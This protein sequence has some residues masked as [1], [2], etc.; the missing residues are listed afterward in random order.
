MCPSRDHLRQS[1]CVEDNYVLAISAFSELAY[2]VNLA[3]PSQSDRPSMRHEPF[4]SGRRVEHVKLQAGASRWRIQ[5]ARE[6][7]KH[8]I[9]ECAAKP[10]AEDE[11]EPKLLAATL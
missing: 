9:K 7:D 5:V 1:K 4:L 2:L 10:T 11:K 3:V 6:L 8:K